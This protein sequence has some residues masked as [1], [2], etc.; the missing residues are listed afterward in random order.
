[1]SGNNIL[2][3]SRGQLDF[4]DRPIVMGILNVTPDSFSDGGRFL[5]TDTAV[6]AGIE[7]AR[8]GA[9]IIDVGPASSRPGST[10]VDTNIQI[11]RAVAVIE[12]LSDA[13]DIPISIDSPDPAVVRASL[14][15]GAS[16]VN[17]I[18]A[19]DAVIVLA[20]EYNVPIV[21]MHMLGSPLTMQ[22]N[23]QY[24]NVVSEVLDFLLDRAEFSCRIGLD[25]KMIIIDPGIGFGKTTEHNIELMK[26]LDLFA[27]LGYRLLI[28]ASRKRFLGEI[29]CEPDPVNRTAATMAAT[30]C[31]TI[32]G[33]DIVRVHDVKANVDLMKCLK[34]I[35]NIE[36]S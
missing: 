23:P 11:D 8:E 22:Q 4:S 10:A 12:K 14:E 2:K 19:S 20:R 5:D 29:T 6:A 16:I 15:A 13:V 30:A 33:V 1:M 9:A 34:K 31:S 36:H 24:E 17:D 21:L 3:W 28:G 7:M 32:A 27:S 25:R 35:V 26:N 18:S